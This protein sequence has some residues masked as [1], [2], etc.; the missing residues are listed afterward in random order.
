MT[1]SV[2]GLRAFAHPVRLRILSLL[3][4]RAL[5]A[6][7]LAAE[8]GIAH[9]S[10]SYH[11]RRLAAAGLV[12]LAEERV[13]RGG[14]ERS[15]RLAVPAALRGFDQQDRREFAES[16]LAEARRRIGL[17]DLSAPTTVGGCRALA[18]SNV[19][20]RTRRAG[21]SADERGV[22]PCAACRDGRRGAGEHDGALVRP[23]R[24]A[25]DRLQRA[26]DAGRSRDDIAAVATID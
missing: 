2:D 26:V 13:R 4:G 12:E 23:R 3:G 1:D 6:T 25:E 7:Q 19:V 8:L 22:R 18:R 5:S 10:A 11:L 20:G 14:T 15:Y 16:A 24:A 9:G 17:A 21:T